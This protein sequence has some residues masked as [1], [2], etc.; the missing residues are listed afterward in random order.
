MLNL[1]KNVVRVGILEATRRWI[2]GE[3]SI[4]STTYYSCLSDLYIYWFNSRNNSVLST[5]DSKYWN[6]PLL[7]RICTR[8]T[9]AW[10]S[11]QVQHQGYKRLRNDVV[12]ELGSLEAWMLRIWDLGNVTQ[13]L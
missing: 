2:I 13:Y 1:N 7:Y 5:F 4:T 8:F 10:N 9:K 12:Q 6:V 3:L 11:W